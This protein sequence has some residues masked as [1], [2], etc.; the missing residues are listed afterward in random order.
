M[1][2]AR[3]ETERRLMAAAVAANERIASCHEVVA[4]PKCG[5]PVGVRCRSM[6]RGYRPL[7]GP[8]RVRI[9]RSPHRQRWTLV[10]APR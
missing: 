9:L 4:C 8:G 7:D 10:Q 1:P 2:S 5:A 6:P 3:E